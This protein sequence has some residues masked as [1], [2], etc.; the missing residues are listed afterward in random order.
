M[1]QDEAG[2]IVFSNETFVYIRTWVLV[3]GVL[4][5]NAP[6]KVAALDNLLPSCEAE[7]AF[8]IRN[9]ATFLPALY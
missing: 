7:I 9:P 1:M 5:A 2:R 4:Y 8:A 6:E 3:R